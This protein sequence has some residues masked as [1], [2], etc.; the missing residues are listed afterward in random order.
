MNNFCV[1][2]DISSAWLKIALTRLKLDII[3]GTELNSFVFQI[4]SA[5]H[6]IVL[7]LKASLK[8]TSKVTH[9]LTEG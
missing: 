5:K 1:L 9:K 3:K 2:S 7:Q 4:V 6:P 8:N